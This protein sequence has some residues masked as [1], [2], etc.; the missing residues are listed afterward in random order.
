MYAFK[1]FLEGHG[2]ASMDVDDSI[3]NC[4]AQGFGITTESFVD[5][6]VNEVDNVSIVALHTYADADDRRTILRQI[7]YH[8][9]FPFLLT[10]SHSEGNH[11]ISIH[12]YRDNHVLYTDQHGAGRI[13]LS[14][15]VQY[16]ILFMVFIIDRDMPAYEWPNAELVFVNGQSMLDD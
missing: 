8:V 15:L 5:L 2:Y 9:A 12:G 13:R 3:A 7:L 11:I 10:Y 6:V 1:S 16:N 14:E 4:V